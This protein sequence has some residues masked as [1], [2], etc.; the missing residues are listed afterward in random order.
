MASCCFKYP[1]EVL[2]NPAL[3]LLL[4]EE[5]RLAG[6]LWGAWATLLCLAIEHHFGVMDLRLGMAFKTWCIGKACEIHASLPSTFDNDMRLS[7]IK[8]KDDP[9]GM[10]EATADFA[11]LKGRLGKTVQDGHWASLA[12]KRES[13]EWLSLTR[14]GE[15]I[16]WPSDVLRP[17]RQ[18]SRR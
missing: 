1:E 15:R 13:V 5:P 16:E 9:K 14:S 6:S 3:P 10:L 2:A 18:R 8:I 11:A 7:S 12:F 4:A 17:N